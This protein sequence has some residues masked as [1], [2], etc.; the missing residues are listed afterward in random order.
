MYR[1]PALLVL[2]HLAAGRAWHGMQRCCGYTVPTGQTGLTGHST[3][4]SLILLLA[5]GKVKRVGGRT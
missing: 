4:L 3:L 5:S 1:S 2:M